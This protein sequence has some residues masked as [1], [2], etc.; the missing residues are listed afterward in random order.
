[1]SP[2]VTLT[3]PLHGVSADAVIVH[4]HGSS[5]EDRMLSTTPWVIKR[6][7]HIFVC[8]FV[9]NQPILMQFSLIDL[10]M[11]STCESMNFTDLT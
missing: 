10:K 8:N 2:V 7:Q 4:L 6:S 9:K 1:V 5:S 3:I 11:N